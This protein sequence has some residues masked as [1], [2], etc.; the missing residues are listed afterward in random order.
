MR[1]RIHTVTR[2]VLNEY[3]D[4]NYMMPLKMYLNMSDEDKAYECAGRMSWMLTDFIASNPEVD[5][6]I[7][8][9][10]EKGKIASDIFDQDSYEIAEIIGPLFHT[11]LAPYADDF[12]NYVAQQGDTD[13]PL[14]VVADYERDVKN[15]W[16]IHMTDNLLG[17]SHEGF[18]IGVS[19]DELAYTPGRGTTD[20]KYGPGY[21]F[22][23]TADNAYHAE[24]TGYGECC[25]LFQASGVQIYHYGD[26]EHQVIFYGPSARNL[27]FIYKEEYGDYS[28]SWV[29]KSEI[30]GRLLCHFDDL[31]GCVN[32]AIQNF[33]QYRNHLVG[34]YKQR[35]G[36][37]KR[38]AIPDEKAWW[39]DRK[40]KIAESVGKQMDEGI[41]SRYVK[42]T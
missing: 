26:E 27:I 24:R 13:E 30:T 17:I 19:I 12:V 32:W 29:I 42:L 22:A 16:L 6:I 7:E 38:R 18:N 14:F 5:E 36:F 28:G 35:V 15:E 25:I 23:F 34:R 20:Y 8:G 9:L 33:P 3:L 31:Q 11:V 21:N 41:F 2:Q 37:E 1:D 4:M 40:E 10:I 39:R